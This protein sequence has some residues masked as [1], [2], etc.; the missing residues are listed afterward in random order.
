MTVPRVETV[1]K[2]F[3]ERQD[4]STRT[5]GTLAYTKN[6]PAGIVRV[7]T[8]PKVFIKILALSTRT[9]GTLA[10]TKNRPA[11]FCHKTLTGGK[12]C[13]TLAGTYI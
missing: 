1:P 9:F 2:V 6:C 8:V 7:E 10:R 13:G 11:G 5:F 3:I 4:L 12:T